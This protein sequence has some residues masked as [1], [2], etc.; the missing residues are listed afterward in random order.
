MAERRRRD[1]LTLLWMAPTLF[2]IVII[3]GNLPLLP[4]LADDNTPRIIGDRAFNQV[5]GFVMGFLSHWWWY[6]ENANG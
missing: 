4:C 1:W 2:V 5:L 6:R 3:V